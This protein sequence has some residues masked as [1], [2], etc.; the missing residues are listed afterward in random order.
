MD[1]L[2]TKITIKTTLSLTAKE[3]NNKI[4]NTLVRK[5]R[6]NVEGKCM[7]SGYIRPDSVEIVSRSLGMANQ[8]QFNGSH[9]F[10]IEYVA[11]ICMPVEGDI[12]KCVATVI[13]RCGII[14]KAMDI[15]PSPVDVLLAKEHHINSDEFNK[16]VVG[17]K[18]YIKVF[19]KRFNVNEAH[20][21]VI[22]LLSTK[23]DYDKLTEQITTKKE[24]DSVDADANTEIEEIEE[25][26]SDIEEIDSDIEEIEEM[27]SDSDIEEIEEIEEI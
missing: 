7:K 11:D 10:T 6:D 17:D 21:S 16:L 18:V 8:S 12:I 19:G 23:K 4:D 1:N 3:M 13:N 2:F 5:I 9:I 20:I 14:L 24:M 22:G 26:D 15:S 27:D 25:M